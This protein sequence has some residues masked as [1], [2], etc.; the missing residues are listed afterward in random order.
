MGP[1]VGD[2]VYPELLVT[3]DPERIRPWFSLLLIELSLRPRL[4][5]DPVGAVVAL[6]RLGRGYDV[7]VRGSLLLAAAPFVGPN[8]E[9][10]ESPLTRRGIPVAAP[11]P[12]RLRG[13]YSA[14]SRSWA[15]ATAVRFGVAATSMNAEDC[16]AR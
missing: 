3:D 4:N 16:D 1:S 2:P 5:I 8:D 6:D 12:S 15:M 10:V 11:M 9:E 13:R 14:A 7:D